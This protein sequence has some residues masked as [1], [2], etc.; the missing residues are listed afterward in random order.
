MNSPNESCDRSN[1]MCVSWL[2]H[3]CHAAAHSVFYIIHYNSR[4]SRYVCTGLRCL[5]LQVSFRKRATYYRALLRGKTCK[6]KASYVFSPPCTHV[7][8]VMMYY[9]YIHIYIH[10]FVCAQWHISDI[11]CVLWDTFAPHIW[12]SCAHKRINHITHV[13]ESCHT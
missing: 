11:L 7:T 4:V 2:I 8:C 12:M 3:M 10:I 13:N 9:I 6:D 1:Q 5:K